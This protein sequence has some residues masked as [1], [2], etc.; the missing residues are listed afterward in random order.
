MNT[1]ET[2]VS[3]GTV[4][5]TALVIVFCSLLIMNFLFLGDVDKLS[6]DT[7]SPKNLSTAPESFELALRAE[8]PRFSVEEMTRTRSWRELQ[9]TVSGYAQRL[10]LL[11]RQ[12]RQRLFW[13]TG[14]AVLSAI[15]LAAFSRRGRM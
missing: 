1:N 8:S 11:E 10:E 13:L 2:Y 3:N 4:T 5:C 7:I 6:I 14:M 15:G 12:D 9:N